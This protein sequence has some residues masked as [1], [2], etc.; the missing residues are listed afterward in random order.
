MVSTNPY[1][2]EP[3]TGERMTVDEYFALEELEL[4]HRYE[5]EDG[6]IRM[7]S[8]DSKAHDDIT[9]NVRF[10]LKAQFASGPCSASGPNLRTQVTP[11]RKYYYPDVVVSCDVADRHPRNKLIRSPRVVVEV[12]SPGTEADDRGKKLQAYQAC[13]T[14]QEY[15][16]VSQFAMHVEVYSRRDDGVWRSQPCV[17]SAG[18][19]IVLESIDV[20]IPIT[21]FYDGINFEEFVEEE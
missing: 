1:R 18:D 8:G 3:R 9:F 14:I 11:S 17:Y 13:D 4:E 7:M 6:V 5:F 20:H 19:T 12:L 16:L 15:V 21:E 10:A 2:N